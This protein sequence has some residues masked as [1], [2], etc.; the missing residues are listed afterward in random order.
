M[1]T[2]IVIVIVI[3]L[4][5]FFLFKRSFEAFNILD[6]QFSDEN[7]PLNIDSYSKYLNQDDSWV[8]TK[9]IFKPVVANETRQ[10]SKYIDAPILTRVNVIQKKQVPKLIDYQFS[11]YNFPSEPINSMN[12]N[13]YDPWSNVKRIDK[14]IIPQSITPYGKNLYD[15]IY[16]KKI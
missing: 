3:I 11:V 10:I 4:L 12:V 14:Y 2:Y 15:E 13:N 7:K 1:K 16:S 9:K 6:F 8:S 5:L